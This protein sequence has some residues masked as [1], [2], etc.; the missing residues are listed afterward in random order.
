MHQCSGT[1]TLYQSSHCCREILLVCSIHAMKKGI[2]LHI[3]E[4]PFHRDQTEA[5]LRKSHAV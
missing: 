1:H 4:W 2:Q 5:H 3:L